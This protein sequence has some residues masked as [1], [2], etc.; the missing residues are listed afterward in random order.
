MRR[1]IIVAFTPT[2][3]TPTLYKKWQ[4]AVLRG[5]NKRKKDLDKLHPKFIYA[6]GIIG[7]SMKTKLALNKMKP[8]EAKLA[9]EFIKCAKAEAR[10]KKK[11]KKKKATKTKKKSKKQE[12]SDDDDPDIQMLDVDEKDAGYAYHI[13]EVIPLIKPVYLEHT[14]NPMTF[15][16][17]KVPD[18]RKIKDALPAAKWKELFEETKRWVVTSVFRPVIL[19]LLTLNSD[20][21]KTFEMR[22]KRVAQLN[23]NSQKTKV[24]PYSIVYKYKNWIQI[25]IQAVIEAERW[26]PYYMKDIEKRSKQL[27]RQRMIHLL[28]RQIQ[29]RKEEWTQLAAFLFEK[30]GYNDA[31]LEVAGLSRRDMEYSYDWANKL[32][33]E[34]LM[35]L[36]GPNACKDFGISDIANLDVDSD[37]IISAASS[38][39]QAANNHPIAELHGFMGDIKAKDKGKG[40]KPSAK[41]QKK[42]PKGNKQQKKSSKSDKITKISKKESKKKHK[43][44]SSVQAKADKKLKSKSK[45]NSKSKKSKSVDA[46]LIKKGKSNDKKKISS[47]SKKKKKSTSSTN[48][49]SK[50]KSKSNSKTKSKSKKSKSPNPNDEKQRKMKKQK[51]IKAKLSMDKQFHSKAKSKKSK[52]KGKKG[53]KSKSK[54]SVHPCTKYSSIYNSDDEYS[55]SS[56]SDGY[57]PKWYKKHKKQIKE[58]IPTKG[59]T[60]GDWFKINHYFL[61]CA[62]GNQNDKSK[63]KWYC[64]LFL[65]GCTCPGIYS[66]SYM[67][68][69]LYVHMA[70]DELSGPPWDVI[71][72]RAMVCSNCPKEKS[73]CLKKEDWEKHLKKENCGGKPTRIPGQNQDSR[74]VE[75][76]EKEQKEQGEDSSNILSGSDSGSSSASG[77]AS[78]STSGSIF[79]I[80]SKQNSIDLDWVVSENGDE[81]EEED[82]DDDD[83]AVNDNAD[84]EE[85]DILMDSSEGNVDE[86]DV[87]N[88]DINSDPSLLDSDSIDSEDL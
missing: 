18:I 73:V 60:K 20:V 5:V 10:D 17:I 47:K 46:L 64:P 34:E 3:Q 56:Y 68:S 16:Y 38:G 66:G 37:P 76:W 32:D 8:G 25:H 61:V 74:W 84:D 33:I 69:H 29:K 31:D 81:E 13:K 78:G 22:S 51:A 44:S 50:K 58:G 21:A 9:R 55:D 43:K 30:E 79:T 14:K 52:S 54:F 88:V 2:N 27:V 59:A 82:D 41:E 7:K 19:Q 77:S 65:V 23:P 26:W 1:N 12:E 71:Q 70:R 75:T 85:S 40:T 42:I 53:K 80:G 4:D 24:Y 57:E 62:R 45:S 15:S 48:S 63:A 6:I 28:W 11:P 49:N 86:T 83:E 35:H 87:Q 67:P 39:L 72:G 36:H